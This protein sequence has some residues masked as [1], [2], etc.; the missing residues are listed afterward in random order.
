MNSFFYQEPQRFKTINL[1]SPHEGAWT[2]YSICR[3]DYAQ[4][5]WRQTSYR[6]QYS[7]DMHPSIVVAQWPSG[8]SSPQWRRI[9]G[10]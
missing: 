9:M 8:P 4:I 5:E 1:L 7:V 2:T 10:Y 6:L 3:V